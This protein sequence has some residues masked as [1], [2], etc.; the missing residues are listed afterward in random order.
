MANVLFSFCEISNAPST[1]VVIFKPEIVLSSKSTLYTADVNA[2]NMMT[3]ETKTY[4]FMFKNLKL[5][6][7]NHSHEWELL[8]RKN[9]I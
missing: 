7:Y 4:L 8:K 3:A 9:V 2:I 5:D 1:S 6:L